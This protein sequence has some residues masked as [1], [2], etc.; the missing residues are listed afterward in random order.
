MALLVVGTNATSHTSVLAQ[1]VAAA[2]A[3]H[4]ILVLG[5][6]GQVSQVF[7]NSHKR[8]T[9]VEVVT[10][11]HAERLLDHILTHQHGMV[12]A[13]RLHTS[14]RACKSLGQIVQSLEAQLTRNHILIF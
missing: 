11:N 6:L 1:R 5:S 14:L 2:E 3:H 8:V 4:C 7:A 9:A 10:V 12:G 13:P